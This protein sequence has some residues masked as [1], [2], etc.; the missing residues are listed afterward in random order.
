MGLDITIGVLVL[1]AGIRGWLKGFVLQAIRLVAL[2]SCVFLADPLR[3]LARPYVHD[4]FPSIQPELMDRFLWWT[5]AII[6]YLLLSGIPSSLVRLAR[7]RPA[8]ELEARWS[9]SGA[10]FL[11]GVLKGFVTVAF[12][13]WGF[14]T[15]AANR[16]TQEGG[17]IS[18][19][20]A[21][22]RLL[23]LA[24][25]YHPA[26]RIWTSDPVRLY[27]HRIKTRGLWTAPEEPAPTTSPEPD[28][29]PPISAQKP[30]RTVPAELPK[31]PVLSIPN[32]RLPSPSSPDFLNELDRALNHEGV[33]KSR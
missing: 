17:W 25:T 29:P 30:S 23:P 5:A 21:T 19:Q 33:S 14:D 10:G 26:E 18:Q 12:L 24:R 16:Y 32:S 22:S 2:V 27:V 13:L 1:L 3:D 8:A 9:D 4:H 7:R 28:L 11:L 20:I 15:Y 6:A 31:H